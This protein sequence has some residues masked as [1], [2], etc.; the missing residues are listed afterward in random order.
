MLSKPVRRDVLVHRAEK[1][2]RPGRDWGLGSAVWEWGSCY[3]QGDSNQVT[4]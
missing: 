1:P 2:G 4:R 3:G